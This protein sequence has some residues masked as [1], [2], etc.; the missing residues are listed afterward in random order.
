MG[1]HQTYQYITG[2]PE[3]EKRENTKEGHFEEII[4]KNFSRFGERH[5]IT[6]P[7]SLMNSK[8]YKS[9]HWETQYSHTVRRVRQILRTSL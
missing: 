4:Y 5:K 7:K 9:D 2:I 8:Q 6:H 1:Q 3:R